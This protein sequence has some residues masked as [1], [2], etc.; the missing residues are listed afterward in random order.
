MTEAPR[1]Y[2]KKPLAAFEHGTRIYAPSGGESCYRVI[3]TDAIGGRRFHKFAREEDA[4]A[5]ARELEAYLAARTPLYGRKNEERTVGTLAARYNEF[6]FGKSIR[7]RERQDSLLRC[8]ILPEL[9]ET[10]LSEWTPAMSEEILA[11]ARRTLAPQTVQVVGSCMRSL[12]TFAHKNRWLPREVDP[13]WLVS[14]SI[15]GEFQG[16][17]PGFV[18]LDSLPNDE[19]CQALFEGF[20]T[21]DQPDWA[22]AMALKHR[23]G[24][25]WGEL[26]ALRPCDVEFSPYR[27]LQIH[28][29]IEQSAAGLAVKSTK[30]KQKRT[31]IFPASLEVD[32]ADHVERVRRRAGNDALL[33]SLPDGRPVERRQFQRLWVRAARHAGWPIRSA[34]AAEWHPHDLRH[35]AACWMLFDVRLDPAVVSRMLGHAN[36]AFTLSRYVGVRVGADETAQA[37]TEDW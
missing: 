10:R 4:R 35:V 3:A 8:W 2:R 11:R 12:V 25:R 16:Q 28:R 27:T 31:S 9:G 21:L 30:N 13:M 18:P 7:Y 20:R 34:N 33:F 32:L 26:I 29:A 24:A 37:M 23:S 22:L 15:K 1:R 36:P 6:L 14:Y 19:Q 5:K 17:T